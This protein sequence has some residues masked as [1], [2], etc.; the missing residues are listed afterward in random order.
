MNSEN[1]LGS[2]L[3]IINMNFNKIPD[4][5]LEK[6]LTNIKELGPTKNPI[7][8]DKYISM[9]SKKRRISI[10]EEFDLPRLTDFHASN[11]PVKVSKIFSMDY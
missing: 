9:K 11:S 6:L 7:M 2:H 3:F 4:N 10:V 5:D 8:Y 1:F